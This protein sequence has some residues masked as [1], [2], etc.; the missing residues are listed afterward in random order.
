[1]NE[2]ALRELDGPMARLADGDRSAFDEVYR[3]LAAPMRV[4]C[5]KILREHT[6]AEDAAQRA[7]LKVFERASEYDCKRPAIAWALAIAGWE[8]RTA[9]RQQ[10]RQR[11]GP[12]AAAYE[13]IDGAS[14]PEEALVDADLLTSALASLEQLS[15]AD[16][17]TLAQAFAEQSAAE[18][19]GPTFRKRKQRAL[20]RLRSTWRRLYEHD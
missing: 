6:A 11:I 1:M 19:E 16:Q 12:E 9:L 17:Q 13:V 4:F 15:A 5:T 18:A 20:E 14:G 7:L 2:R 10:K 3:L 8:C